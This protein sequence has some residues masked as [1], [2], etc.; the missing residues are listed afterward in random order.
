MSN[1]ASSKH[2]YIKRKQQ[3]YFSK[4]HSFKMLSK[5]INRIRIE[6]QQIIT[7][8]YFLLYFMPYFNFQQYFVSVLNKFSKKKYIES[9][10]KYHL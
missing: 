8:N 5:V 1:L 6:K 7:Y 10:F 9:Y 4:L 2:N 3:K